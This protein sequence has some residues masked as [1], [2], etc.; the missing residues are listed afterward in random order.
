M[1]VDVIP[2][3]VAE[4]MFPNERMPL[5]L[6]PATRDGDPI[7]MA[8]LHKDWLRAKLIDHGALLLRGF[9]VGSVAG[10]DRVTRVI[11]DERAEY[12]YRSTPRTSLGD[13]IYTA[14]EYPADREIPLHN[15][16]AYQRTWPLRLAFCCV[17]PAPTGG[18]TPIADMKRVN[19][20]IGSDILDMFEARRV[21]YTRHYHPGVD[22]SWQDVFQTSDRGEVG[23]YC[24]ANDIACEWIDEDTLKTAQVCQGTARHPVT[25]ERVFFNQAHLFHVSSLGRE[26]AAMMV[27][28]FGSDRLPRNASYGDGGEIAAEHLDTILGAF[29]S[30]S[31]AFRWQANDVL[32]VDN[33]QVAHGRN[34]FTGQ[35]KVIAALLDPYSAA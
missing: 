18:E 28:A 26:M 10:F 1:T 4:R 29:R 22:L 14:T 23:R 2:G 6:Q 27:E 17:T 9:D 8:E 33:M 13:G 15:E 21:R 12:R 5:V 34:R 25:G 20:A 24:D 19:A 11:S 3:V 16:N 35:R 30:E 31:V 7:A 32:L